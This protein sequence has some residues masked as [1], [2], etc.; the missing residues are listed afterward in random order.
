ME[1]YGSGTSEGLCGPQKLAHKEEGLLFGG[2]FVEHAN[3]L[4]GDEI[5]DARLDRPLV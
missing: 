1:K 2:Y 5:L 3:G 4:V